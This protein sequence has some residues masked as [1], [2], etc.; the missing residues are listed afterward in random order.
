MYNKTWMFI[1]MSDDNTVSLNNLL[2]LYYDYR[3]LSIQIIAESN[4]PLTPFS[5]QCSLFC[6]ELSISLPTAA[7]Y[8]FDCQSTVVVLLYDLN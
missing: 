1:A 7:V 5:L 2:V 8:S 3:L 6:K 4:K